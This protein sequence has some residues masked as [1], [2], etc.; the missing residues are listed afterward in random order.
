MKKVI[1]I[2]TLVI[3]LGYSSTMSA[4][5]NVSVNINNQPAWGPTGYDNANYYYFPDLNIYFDVNN[6]LFYYKSGS[7]W[8]SNRYLPNKYA[9]YDLYSLYKV[10]INDS[11]PWKNN[12]NDKKQYS[13]YKN[14]KQQIPIRYATDSRYDQSRKNT[15]NWVNMDSKNT[16]QENKPQK[17]QSSNNQN[18][19]TSN[20]QTASDGRSNNKSDNTS[21]RQ[22]DKSNNNQSKK[23]MNT[24]NHNNRQ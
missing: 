2:M 12:N 9:Q 1:F 14:N 4:Q 21:G 6:S 3:A 7:N 16:R 11:Q 24:N 13:N 19:K 5:L 10:V 18:N 20:K 17:N 23:N 8:T 22:S 15:L